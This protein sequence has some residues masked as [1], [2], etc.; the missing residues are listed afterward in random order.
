[1]ITGWTR[2]LRLRLHSLRVVIAVSVVAGV[3]VASILSYL[4][5]TS[6]LREAHLT[7]IRA[8]MDNLGTLAA[9]ALREPLWQFEAEQANSI[10]EA[11][12]TNP[13][14]VSIRVWD[15]KG[16]LFARNQRAAEDPNQVITAMRAIERNHA[17]VGRLEIQMS[18]AGYLRQVEAVRRQHL[19]SAAQIS[20]GALVVIL[21]LMHWRLVRPLDRLVQ[22]SGRI[23]QG[24][25]DV[26]IRPVFPDEVGALA[27]SLD[28][29]RRAL[30]HLIAELENR[31]TELVDANEHLEQRVL[32]RTQS[33]Q[34]TLATLERA[35]EEIVQTEKLASLG[36]VVAGVAHELNTP[37]GNAL[38]IISTLQPEIESL[39]GELATGTMRRSHLSAFVGRSEE[40]L[41]LALNNLQRAAQLIS[42][43]KQVAV[44]QTSDQVRIFDLAEVTSELLNMLQPTLRKHACEVER[45]LIPGLRCVSYPGRYGQVLTNLVV[46]AMTH[47]FEPGQG[48]QVRV[49]IGPVDA[50]SVELRVSDNGCGMSEEVRERVFDPFFTT[51][52]GRGGTGLGMHIV[53]TIVTRV[54]RG[55][56]T[57]T[58]Q[59]GVGTQVRVVFPRE[60]PD[61]S[62]PQTLPS[63]FG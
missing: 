23:E 36:R 4:E 9:L 46:N 18:T 55:Q 26:P 22:A 2:R 43:F 11:A 58:S 59:V 3:L 54:L 52:M 8:A 30:L 15:D 60:L 25:L 50:T 1:M 40:G 49:A 19:R 56:I 27:E 45:L 61:E 28:A 17:L 10:M 6:N 5:Q 32:E 7:Q 24:Q 20:I 44:D 47:A 63:A 48:G 21:L 41:T 33:L 16:T 34:N 62:A 31:N 13:D 42:D 14:V 38:T 57:V 53:H 39:K 51:K 35:Q 29:T 12:F 37:I